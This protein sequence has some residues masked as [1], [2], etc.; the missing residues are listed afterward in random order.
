LIPG[1]IISWI[2]FPGVI[3]HEL[4]HQIF[5]YL[6]K[7]PVYQVCYFRF[8]NP[9]GYVIHGPA[10]KHWHNVIVAI[11]PFLVNTIVGAI[12]AAPAAL[13]ILRFHSADPLDYFLGWLGVSV[14]MHSFPSTGDAK[15]ILATVKEEG[16][17]FHTKLWAYPVVGL[18]YVGAL[19]SIFWLD[20]LY[21][22]AVAGGLPTLIVKVIA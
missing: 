15:S 14:A 18:I 12:I 1:F 9:S 19:G 20:A 10:R 5:C 6:Y 13:P 3:V 21:G 22:V 11:G 7:I 8:G 17:P 2:T 16:V 4:A